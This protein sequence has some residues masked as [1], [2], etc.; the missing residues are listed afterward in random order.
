MGQSFFTLGPGSKCDLVCLDATTG[1]QKWKESG[2]GDYASLTGVNDSILVLDSTGE[3]RLVRASASKYEELG[4][5]HFV[6]K[7]WAS[8]AF[9]EG[10]LYVKDA[11]KL[12]AVQ[13]VP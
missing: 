11:T 10:K 8:P 4:R 6:G 9:V 3:L 2:L 1:Q 7:T 12:V 13:L 5:A